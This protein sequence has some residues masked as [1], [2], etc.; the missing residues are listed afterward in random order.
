VTDTE[1]TETGFVLGLSSRP[2]PGLKWSPTQYVSFSDFMY[3]R[4]IRLII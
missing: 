1:V 2:K 4:S 3:V